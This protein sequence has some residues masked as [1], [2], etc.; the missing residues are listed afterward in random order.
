MRKKK[1]VK[2]RQPGIE[3]GSTAWKAAMLTTIPLTLDNFKLLN[4]FILFISDLPNSIVISN[5]N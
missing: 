1:K 5:L 3:P 4:I 2:M